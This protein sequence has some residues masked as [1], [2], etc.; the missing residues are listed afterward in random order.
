MILD[1]PRNYDSY[2]IDKVPGIFWA[3]PDGI[4]VSTHASH[5][6][7]EPHEDSCGTMVTLRTPKNSLAKETSLLTSSRFL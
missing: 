2:N 1:Q 4:K 7:F 5:T 3:R 6:M